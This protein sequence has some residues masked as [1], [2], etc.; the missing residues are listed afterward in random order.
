ML[1]GP[2]QLGVN[3]TGSFT[4]GIK[5]GFGPFLSSTSARDTLTGLSV[6]PD[7][8]GSTALTTERV[9]HI[10]WTPRRPEAVDLFIIV[11]DDRTGLSDSAHMRVDVAAF[12]VQFSQWPTRV[13]VDEP[14]SVTIEIFG[15]KGPYEVQIFDDR[16]DFAEFLVVDDA[17][18]FT[19][20]P[21]TFDTPGLHMLMVEVTDVSK[22]SKSADPVAIGVV[23]R[24]FTIVSLEF[25]SSIPI[26]SSAALSATWSGDPT[27]PV[28][29]HL[30]QR[31]GGCPAGFSCINPSM[32]F[33]GPANPLVFPGAI[34]CSGGITEPVFFDYEVVLVDATGLETPPVPAG[35][36]CRP[37]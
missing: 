2:L 13:A 23:A 12:A 30:R 11:T 22:L 31:P 29:M 6:T 14:T 9:H 35:V 33:E 16:S 7:P 17:G 15:G 19:I 5:G 26:D 3:Q 28:T 21:L 1:T 8:T 20:S 10:N 25:P 32:T 37:D 24:T 18:A 27:F 34:F 4:F 36:T